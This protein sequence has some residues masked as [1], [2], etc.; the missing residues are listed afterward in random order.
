[1]NKNNDLLPVSNK[2]L[3]VSFDGLIEKADFGGD[4]GVR[5][6]I[7]ARNLYNALGLSARSYDR[8]ISNN[9]YNSPMWTIGVDYVIVE[10]IAKNKK[11]KQDV[12]CRIPMAK[13][14]CMKANTPE[15]VLV[16]N[17]FVEQETQAWALRN[18]R[19]DLLNNEMIMGIIQTA[20]QKAVADAVNQALQIERKENKQMESLLL[21]NKTKVSDSLFRA[22]LVKIV[23]RIAKLHP[24]KTFEE[25]WREA[26]TRLLCISFVDWKQEFWQ[27]DNKLDYLCTKN[28]IYLVRLK[29]ILLDMV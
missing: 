7:N 16:K 23:R 9:I 6:A 12:Y 1:M 4:I 2:S 27:A 22:D 15:A 28:K 18:N 26:Y 24:A 21:E 11:T 10:S 19:Q 13:M 8:W 3:Q 25:I 17:Y 20:T 29:E 14:L 5:K